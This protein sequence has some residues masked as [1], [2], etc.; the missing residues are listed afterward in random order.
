MSGRKCGESGRN[1]DGGCGRAECGDDAEAAW[2]RG[3]DKTTGE[4]QVDGDFTAKGGSRLPVMRSITDRS[5]PV[6]TSAVQAR[7]PGRRTAADR[8]VRCRRG[9]RYQL[10]SVMD[11]GVS[12]SVGVIPSPR[13][14]SGPC[15]ST[16]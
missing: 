1:R 6:V 11:G 8:A 10:R 4:W 16:T 14:G 13:H 12:V 15:Y 2:P 5:A 7:P 9:F 3:E